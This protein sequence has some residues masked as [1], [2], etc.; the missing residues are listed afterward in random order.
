[1]T[2]IEA[3]VSDCRDCTAHR[4]DKHLLADQEA[5]ARRTLI[6]TEIDLAAALDRNRRHD[7]TIARLSAALD[8]FT[9]PFE[10]G[11][12]I[13]AVCARCARLRDAPEHLTAEV[14]VRSS[15]VPAHTFAPGIT[16][17]CV[18]PVAGQPCGHTRDSDRHQTKNA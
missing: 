15:A 11:T 3:A 1:M 17:F 10:P 13:R 18:F 8:A 5:R 4:A 16:Q 6:W 12:V 7:A 2:G 14:V 9:H